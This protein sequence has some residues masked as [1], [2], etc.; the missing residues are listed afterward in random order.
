MRRVALLLSTAVALFAAAPARAQVFTAVL[1]GA[2]ETPTPIVTNATG[3]GS[4]T[5]TGG[6]GAWNL[7]FT[8]NW[9]GLQ[10]G[11]VVGAHFHNAPVGVTGGVVRGYPAGS[12]SSP[13]GTFNDTWTSADA[14][15]LT[16]ALVA[17]MNLGNIYFNIHTTSFSS[18]EIRGQLVPVPEPGS[19]ALA[20]VGLAGLLAARRRRAKAA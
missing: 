3:T 6:P 5:L 13:N 11:S 15:P 19:L 2:Q 8:L 1:N 17:Q 7:A 18:G 10:G 9:T 16:D 4:F 20:G 12:F 14:Q